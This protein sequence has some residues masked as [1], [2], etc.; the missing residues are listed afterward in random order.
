MPYKETDIKGEIELTPTLPELEIEPTLGIEP[1]IENQLSPK[2]R[3]D[4]K[5][6]GALR[7]LQGLIGEGGIRVSVDSLERRIE[8]ARNCIRDA[9]ISLGELE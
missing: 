4:S 7:E 2:E 3:I 5:L 6:R 1:K 9:L 8:E